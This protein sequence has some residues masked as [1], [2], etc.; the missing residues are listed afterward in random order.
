MLRL[1]TPFMFG[2]FFLI[3]GIVLYLLRGRM[4]EFK[5]DGDQSNY[6]DMFVSID[7]LSTLCTD[8]VN[9]TKWNLL[10]KY[11]QGKESNQALYKMHIV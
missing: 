9:D 3:A 5:V 8:S 1:Y 10:R 4:I 6:D 11:A 2:I 7:D